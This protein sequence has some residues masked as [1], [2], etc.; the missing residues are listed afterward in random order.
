MYKFIICI[1]DEF[2]EV[3]NRKWE[4]IRCEWVKIHNLPDHVYF[5]HSQ[6]VKVGGVKCQTCHGKVEEYEVMK[7]Y[8]PLSMGWCINCHRQTEVKFAEN[9]TMVCEI[10]DDIEL[11][12]VATIIKMLNIIVDDYISE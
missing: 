3:I 7:Q 11:L 9:N 10:D 5:N 8:A 6:H 1:L 12:N 2:K 4:F